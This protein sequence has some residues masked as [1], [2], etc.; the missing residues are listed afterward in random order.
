MSRKNL[1]LDSWSKNSRTSQNVRF[2]KLQY[3]SIELRNKGQFCIWFVTSIEATNVSLYV[4]VNVSHQL[5][6]VV[7]NAWA[8]PKLCHIVSQLHLKNEMSFKVIFCMWQRPIQVTNSINNFKWA[9]SGMPKVVENKLA[10]CVAKVDLGMNMIFAYGQAYIDTSI[11][12]SPF[13]W[14][15]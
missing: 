3:L 2:F 6:D 9:W 7:R 12:F 4:S 14:V 1:V 15:W 10:S 11:S 8:C 5:V 13:V